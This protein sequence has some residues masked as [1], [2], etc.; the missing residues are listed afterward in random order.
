M[1]KP[2]SPEELRRDYLQRELIQDEKRTLKRRAFVKRWIWVSAVIGLAAAIPN[3]LGVTYACVAHFL[4]S[5]AAGYALLYFK[6]GHLT[7]MA[8]VGLGNEIIS[9]LAGVFNPF[10]VL[11]FCIAGAIIGMG[12]RLEEDLQ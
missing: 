11:G 9:L 3:Y 6:R 7:G 4:F 8:L 1:D 10:G 5:G 2:P 12:L